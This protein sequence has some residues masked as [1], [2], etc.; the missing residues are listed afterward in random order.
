VRLV[1]FFQESAKALGQVFETYRTTGQSG[2][3]ELY[4]NTVHNYGDGW[5]PDFPSDE[6]R[7]KIWDTYRLE[8]LAGEFGCIDSDIG[9]DIDRDVTAD[10]IM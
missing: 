10:E 9:S 1:E 6:M 5:R 7:D 4:R 2:L 3:S 8:R